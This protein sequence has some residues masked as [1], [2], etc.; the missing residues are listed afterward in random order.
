MIMGQYGLR[1]AGENIFSQQLVTLVQVILIR[2]LNI[3]LENK[4]YLCFVQLKSIILNFEPKNIKSC[5]CIMS[6]KD[7]N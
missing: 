6:W 1:N 3:H 5:N 4:L 2:K 7:I